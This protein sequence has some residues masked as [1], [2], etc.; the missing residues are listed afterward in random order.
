LTLSFFVILC[1][2]AFAADKYNEWKV[3]KN[4]TEEDKKKEKEKKEKN[5]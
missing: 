3:N 1:I 2:L 5:I 4:M